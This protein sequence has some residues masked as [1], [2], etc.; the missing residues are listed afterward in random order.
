MKSSYLKDEKHVEK[1]IIEKYLKSGFESLSL[2]ELALTI[3]SP[4]FERSY[5]AQ[6]G[7]EWPKEHKKKSLERL[8]KAKFNI[9]WCLNQNKKNIPMHSKFKELINICEKDNEQKLNEIFRENAQYMQ[10]IINTVDDNKK[11][12]L[13]ISAK[14]GNVKMIKFLITKGF[15]IFSRDKYLR[16]PFLIS[17]Q[18]GRLKA[19]EELLKYGSEIFAKDSIGRTSLHYAVC[20]DSSLLVKLI[21]EKE[22]SL[23][24]SQDTYGRTPLHYVVFNSNSF[25]VEMAK[26]LINNGSNIN[27]L[28]EEKMTPL[29]FAAENGKGKIIPIL[30]KNGADPLLTC[31]RDNK[32]SLDLACNER[33][34]ELI[35]KFSNGEY[36]SEINQKKL[37]GKIENGDIHN[38]SNG[39]SFRNGRR[40]NYND[41]NEDNYYNDDL[42]YNTN[43]NKL[44]SFLKN[45]QDYGVKTQ[46]HLVKPELYS[47]S[48]L[49]KVNNINELYHFFGNYT[50][51]ES[52]L[53]IYN[54]M[55]PFVNPLPKSKD[56]EQNMNLFF[57]KNKKGSLQIQSSNNILSNNN[58]IGFSSIQNF[59]QGYQP[60]NTN[61]NVNNIN[62]NNTNLGTNINDNNVDS[63]FKDNYN[64][65]DEEMGDMNI[66][67]EQRME[68][69]NLKNQIND[70]NKKI[71][72][73]KKN[74]ERADVIKVKL[75]IEKVKNENE[76]L[77]NQE[78]NLSNQINILSDNI[79]KYE[80]LTSK[81]EEKEQFQKE[82]IINNLNSQLQDMNNK[83][84]Q[85]KNEKVNNIQTSRFR[86][87]SP[88][89]RTFLPNQNFNFNEEMHILTFCQLA[90][91]DEGLFDILIKFDKDNDMH[92]LKNEFLE[93]FNYLNLPFEYRDT[94]I[95][96]VGFDKNMKLPINKIVNLIYNRD[97]SKVCL[98]NKCLFNIANKIIEVGKNIDDL[99][100]DL[101]NKVQGNIINYEDASPIFI[102]NYFI[103]EEDV[104]NLFLYW[105]STD[106]MLMNSSSKNSSNTINNTIDI[107]S[108]K[109]KIEERKKIID[110]IEE[111]YGK[112]QNQFK[113][114]IIINQNFNET[115]KNKQ[116]DN[117]H[118]FSNNNNS[119]SNSNSNNNN[120][121]NTLTNKSDIY[122]SDIYKSD[123]Y[124]TDNNKTNEKNKYNYQNIHE[125]ESVNKNNNKIKKQIE[126]EDKYYNEFE[127]EE[128]EGNNN[129]QNNNNQIENYSD[130]E[131][132][133][134]KIMG[135]GEE[136]ENEKEEIVN[137]KE[138]NELIESNEI[139]DS[140]HSKIKSKNTTSS[141]LE[142]S[143]INEKVINSTLKKSSSSSNKTK[144]F[145]NN[146]SNIN[147][148]EEIENEELS[149]SKQQSIKNKK[150]KD[151][152]SKKIKIDPNEKFNGEL[153]IQVKNVENLRLPKTLKSP[154]IFNLKLTIEGIEQTTRSK[155]I[156]T[157]DLNDITFNWSPLVLLKD[158]TL[159]DIGSIFKIN[160]ENNSNN[161]VVN[162]GESS[163]N[164][165][166]CLN[167]QNYDQY[168]IDEKF[169][170]LN[171]KHNPIGYIKI[172]AKFIPF[173]FNS[174][175]Y[176]KNGKRKKPF[177]SNNTIKEES[178]NES[179]ISKKIKT[180]KDD[181]IEGNESKSNSNEGITLVKEFDIEINSISNVES[182]N[183]YMCI[184]SK[185]NEEENEIYSSKEENNIKDIINKIPFTLK[186]TTYSSSKEKTIKII[187]QFKQI[188]NDSIICEGI[189]NLNN[190]ENN[191]TVSKKIK[192]SGEENVEMN[193]K[194]T[195]NTIGVND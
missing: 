79:K 176:E 31:N 123:I 148:E 60:N 169:Q 188:D 193:V 119:N 40:N 167:K 155:E 99:C 22:K 102:N 44:I 157:D 62:N 124:N 111:K 7:T 17:C 134:N 53:A 108:F 161:K 13:H 76:M 109:N 186:A 46:Q 126:D 47:G 130:K 4:S 81:L 165:I 2:E 52:A 73:E 77:K 59:S 132:N 107:E 142:V 153:K 141:I 116:N 164:W 105:S 65:Y 95:K 51:H 14:R 159:K 72:E 145:K 55:I 64:Y 122:K 168:V 9:Q 49:E 69:L 18:F 42:I 89:Y 137:K 160:L 87:N 67:N 68:I 19:A 149:K 175:N 113:N 34:R 3:I 170:L 45:I 80:E 174:S 56:G 92:I 183:I 115:D 30:M 93:V 35:I 139:E 43:R 136:E 163:I 98:L 177:T 131:E 128:S 147:E 101:N 10:E 121:N 117:N 138:S 6:T 83:I 54:I 173:G 143:N 88:S 192:L 91:R 97:E 21:I 104:Y 129:I 24:F 57:N 23:I 36:Q 125:E 39:N 90:E 184:I 178:I 162:L 78:D 48:W 191:L 106:S 74:K 185:V 100:N 166:N 32:N 38:K 146:N 85:M 94:I 171:K 118:I 11:S 182:D 194:F 158:R 154:Y 140:E 71:E 70:L 41:N 120:N 180:T 63:N 29:H 61:T 133:E 33:I 190:K 5:K 84:E 152:S 195:I 27:C 103:R 181:N 28:D 96:L 144:T 114:S 187:I 110:F 1:K 127:N 82:T 8:K 150:K 75:E 189:V 179:Q 37:R 172:M 135:N 66:L 25:Q 12:L 50:P 112:K 15:S 86:S 16:T 151:S 26:M 58:N 20:S 156:I